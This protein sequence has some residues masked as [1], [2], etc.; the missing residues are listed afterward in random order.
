MS[1]S[2]IYTFIISFFIIAEFISNLATKYAYYNQQSFYRYSLIVRTIFEVIMIFHLCLNLDKKRLKIFIAIILLFYCFIFGQLIIQLPDIYESFITFNKYIYLFIA[3][4]FSEEI[5]SLPYRDKEKIYSLITK[6][7][8]LNTVFIL[9][10]VI[11]NISIFKSFPTMSYR[12]G[13]NGV[14]MAGNEASYVII[15]GLS[16]FYYKCVYEKTN[17]RLFFFF[18]L[19]A[20]LSGMKAVY[21]FIIL[22]SAFHLFSKMKLKQIIKYIG[23]IL[24]PALLFTI[25]YIQSQYFIKH[26][27]FFQRAYQDHGL[28]YML[29]SGRNTIMEKEGSIILSQ[30]TPINY[31]IGGQQIS[32][33]IMEMSFFDLFFFF[34]LA[35]SVLYLILF[36]HLLMKGLMKYKFFIFFFFALLSLAFF[37]G[38]FF[39]SPTL[40][41]YFSLIVISF[42]SSK[43]KTI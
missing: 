5:L 37:G 29:V 31:F 9:I 28:F 22:L 6:I 39:K 7:F 30:W 19:G 2:K 18:L 3:Y 12:F 8:I 11:F 10:G 21:I 17:S 43:L 27:A 41:M 20:M 24:A 15:C 36:Y 32:K 33:Y 4:L 40:A 13:Y 14:F 26:T 25:Y 34:G 23:F 38:H 16:F 35:G 1:K 42:Q